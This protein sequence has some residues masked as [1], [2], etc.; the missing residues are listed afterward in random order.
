MMIA[1]S[2]RIYY[3]ASGYVEDDDG[4]IIAILFRVIL[5]TPVASRSGGAGGWSAR[6]PPPF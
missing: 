1:I 2:F 3:L 6:A 5:Y 4:M